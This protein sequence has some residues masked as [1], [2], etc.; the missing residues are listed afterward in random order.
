MAISFHTVFCKEQKLHFPQLHSGEQ[1]CRSYSCT[2]STEGD[3]QAWEQHHKDPWDFLGLTAGQ[4]SNLK[5]EESVSITDFR[6]CSQHK[7]KLAFNLVE[8]RSKR[9][10]FNLEFSFSV[11]DWH[12]HC[13]IMFQNCL[14]LAGSNWASAG[15]PGT[16]VSMRHSFRARAVYQHCNQLRSSLPFSSSVLNSIL[17]KH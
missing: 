1:L 10:D 11:K 2:K 13:F 14:M 7:I 17:N 6:S 16:F 9:K 8:E 12:Q 15:M 4:V 3:L 5:T